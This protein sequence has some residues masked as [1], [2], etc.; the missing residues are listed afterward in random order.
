MKLRQNLLRLGLA[1]LAVTSIAVTNASAAPLLFCKDGASTTDFDLAT[2]CISGT[3]RHYTPTTD[4]LYSNAGGGDPEAKVEEAIL[5]AT[6]TPVDIF[7]YGDSDTSPSLF[8]LTGISPAGQSGTWAVVDNTVDIAYITVKAANSFALY[9]VSD[10]KMG[11]W[12]TVGILNNGNQQPTV[13]HI[14]F[15]TT[16]D[17]DLP[18]PPASVPVPGTL[19]LLGGSMVGIALW[20]RRRA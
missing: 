12:T 9:E 15:W 13:S 16:Q 10:P 7:L 8:N 19:L 18:N 6:G 5:G 2:G 14:R 3:S 20:R 17:Y 11:T 1:C 4:G